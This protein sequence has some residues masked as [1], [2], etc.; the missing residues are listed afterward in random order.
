[1]E[2]KLPAAASLTKFSFGLIFIKAVSSAVTAYICDWSQDNTSAKVELLVSS[3]LEVPALQQAQK[4]A[5]E[6]WL[7]AHPP[8]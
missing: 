2:I 7:E 8:A 6:L 5:D 4:F 3:G 1:M